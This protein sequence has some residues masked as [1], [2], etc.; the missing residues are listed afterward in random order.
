MHIG[1]YANY[2]C[3]QLWDK[4]NRKAIGPLDALTKTPQRRQLNWE[5]SGLFTKT[6]YLL[7]TKAEILLSPSMAY[8][9]NILNLWIPVVNMFVLINSENIKMPRYTLPFSV[10][11]TRMKMQYYAGSQKSCSDAHH[12]FHNDANEETRKLPIIKCTFLMS[13]ILKYG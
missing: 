3:T 13:M 8:P 11:Y 6:S 2:I 9:W 4:N 1:L 10:K 7:L 5:F 12:I